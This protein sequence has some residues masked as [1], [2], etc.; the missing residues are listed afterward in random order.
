MNRSLF[1]GEGFFETISYKNG[2]FALED[3]YERLSKSAKALELIHPPFEEFKS[4]VLKALEKKDRSKS[5]SIKYNLFY[6]GKKYYANYPESFY[7]KASIKRI[8]KKPSFI[9][10][11]LSSFRRHSKDPII[12]HKTSSYFGNILIKR[13]ALRNGVFDNIILNEKEEVQETSSYNILVI[14]D[15]NIKTPSKE[16][17]LLEGI[18]RKKLLEK[19][20]IEEEKVTVKDLLCSDGLILINSVFGFVEVKKFL[21]KTYDKTLYEPIIKSLKLEIGFHIF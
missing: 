19:N 20:K 9:E 14:K 1:F 18:L 11:G 4:L 12:R 13:E 10:L 21:D 2:F 5:Y 7:S 3:H 6:K 16:S 17:G 15:S 8:Y